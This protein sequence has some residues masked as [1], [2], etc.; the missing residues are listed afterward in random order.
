MASELPLVARGSELA[1]LTA[2]L[3][4]LAKGRGQAV[5]L[6]GEAGIGKSRLLSAARREA[7]KRQLP[8]FRGRAVESGGAYRP[9]VEAFARAAAPFAQDPRLAGIRPTL[10][11][12]LPGW[13]G[14]EGVLAP[15]ADPA[16]V[17]AEALILL[18][19]TLAPEGSA[20]F[21]DDLHWADEDTLSVLGSLVDAAEDV[22]MALFLAARE[23]EVPGPALE[24]LTTAGSVR[25]LP[26][27]RLSSTAVGAALRTTQVPLPPERVAELVA[28]VDGLPLILDE[29]VRQVQESPSGH[30]QL[31][32]GRTTLASA[33]RRRLAGL[34]PDCRM[35]LDALAVLGEADF[36]LLA[37]VTGFDDAR[38]SAALHEGVASTLL[39]PAGTP[40]GVTWRHRL[41]RDVVRD[42][43]LPLE[44]QSRARAAADHLAENPGASEGQ[45]HQAAAM[46]ALAGY[47]HRAAHQLVRAARAAVGSAALGAAERYLGEAQELTGRYPDAAWEVLVQRITTLSL[48][49]R[50]GDA[51]DSGMAALA[52]VTGRDACPLLAATARA[53]FAAGLRA[54]GRHLVSRL[55]TEGDATELD[56]DVLRAHL[57]L[58]YRQAAAGP[59]G[60]RAA[61]HAQAIGRADLACEALLIAAVMARR[62]DPPRAAEVLRRG[63]ALSR[64]HDLSLWEARFLAE[65]G[66][67]D[68]VESSD[69]TQLAAAREVAIAGG[70]AGMVAEL[71]MNIGKTVYAH[72]G[73]VAAYP[74]L[75][76][77][78]AEA[79]RL[80]LLA[81]HA[82]TRSHVAECLLY[83]GDQALPGW[84]RPPTSADF[85]A[86]VA[87]AVEI[88]EKSRPIRW[89]IGVLGERAWLNGDNASAIRLIRES[90]A[91]EQDQ[92]KVPPFW[93]LGMLLDVIDGAEPDE[94]F[95]SPELIGH[96]LNRA[97]LAYATA[98][99]DL[100]HGRSAADSISEAEHLL[101]HTAAA[102]HLQRTVVAVPMY[103]AG[104][105]QAENWLREADSFFG[106]QGERVLQSRARSGLSAIGAKVP[107]VTSATVP[108]HLAGVGITAREAEIL[109]LVNAGLSNHDIADRLVI[110]V[111]TVESHVSSMLLKTGQATRD[112]LPG[113]DG[114]GHR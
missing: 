107:R 37:A 44:Q 72:A 82:Q 47:P 24:R 17:L 1:T 48:A 27:R 57:A 104:I 71:D 21:V 9:L 93:G 4:A 18:V 22:P 108:P 19:Q 36:Q 86:V 29:L 81:L 8:V 64:E 30:V 84:T 105:E 5:L 34:S 102:R 66:V 112:Q 7:A 113:V 67:A 11:R 20:L 100:R 23:E 65:L 76:R 43:L 89:V 50:S 97:A 111:R 77:A 79:R 3:T 68:M 6:I 25:T 38:H 26:L 54:E 35:V 85:D 51:Y 109:R 92:L 101:Q 33:V 56:L 114:D 49:G 99:A 41:I 106:A 74:A 87:E 95:G 42:L 88:G 58:A 94:A 78:D 63:Y 73:A 32:I 39:V 28:A 96:H 55:E 110:S 40:L 59:L 53:A 12:V 98:L 60:E 31:D 90:V 15:M 103:R 14:S 52:G 61:A 46:Y 2:V 75:A 13:V 70:M 10:A 83:A 80:R 91:S 16:A 62:R 45:L 69:P